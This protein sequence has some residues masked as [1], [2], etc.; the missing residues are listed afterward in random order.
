M[1]SS[2]RGDGPA[3][4]SAAAASPLAYREL[5]RQMQSEFARAVSAL[6]KQVETLSRHNELL[7]GAQDKLRA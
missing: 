1:A 2:R 3:P 7:R 6:E 4:S 5:A